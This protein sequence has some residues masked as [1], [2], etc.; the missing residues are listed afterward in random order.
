MKTVYQIKGKGGFKKSKA[1]VFQGK[2]KVPGLS[3]QY[4]SGLNAEPQIYML[5]LNRI[6]LN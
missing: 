6:V 2:G 3:C 1:T 4:W 5:D